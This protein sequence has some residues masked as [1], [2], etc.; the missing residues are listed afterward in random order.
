MRPTRFQFE[1][2]SAAKAADAES[3]Q[4]P[5]EV[6]P[7]NEKALQTCSAPSED[8]GRWWVFSM[9]VEARHS[10]PSTPIPRYGHRDLQSF[11][12]T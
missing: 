4:T 3:F 10:Y 11:G 12:Y 1:N 5:S 8:L 6:L 9:T 7:Q 2:E